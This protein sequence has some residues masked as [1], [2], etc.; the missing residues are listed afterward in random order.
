MKAL[1]KFIA[2]TAIVF[3]VAGSATALDK[4]TPDTVLLLFPICDTTSSL[5]Q[6]CKHSPEKQQ[7]YTFLEVCCDGREQITT[8]KDYISISRP[9]EWFYS[10]KVKKKLFL[11]YEI[12]F[13]DKAMNGGSYHTKTK[14]AAVSLADKL[15]IFETH[16]KNL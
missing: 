16:S 5:G 3:L 11:I 13:T 14:F 7:P 10:F 4:I 2:L 15:Y 6:K 1:S 12:E 9:N 8:S